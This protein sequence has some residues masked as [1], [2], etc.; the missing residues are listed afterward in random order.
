MCAGGI[1]NESCQIITAKYGS[2]VELARE[3]GTIEKEA[4]C[5]LLSV[6]EERE[7]CLP[8]PHMLLEHKHRQ[9]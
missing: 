2:P 5:L 9:A 1:V 7:G 4:A 3:L 8:Q 6:V